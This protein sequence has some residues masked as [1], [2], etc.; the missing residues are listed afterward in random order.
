[1][2]KKKDIIQPVYNA[3]KIQFIQVVPKKDK[4]GTVIRG[5]YDELI[6]SSHWFRH[7]GITASDNYFAHADDVDISRKLAIRGNI[8]LSTKYIAKISGR[9]YEIY[10]IFYAYKNNETEISLKEVD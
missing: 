10:R 2:L 1:M 4:F 9:S 7:L 3:G 5:E 8:E 6:L